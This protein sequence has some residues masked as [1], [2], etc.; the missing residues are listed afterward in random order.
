MPGFCVEEDLA[1]MAN[2]NEV[3]NNIS[4]GEAQLACQGRGDGYHLITENEWLT[5]AENILR[6]KANDINPEVGLQLATST[7]PNST[8]TK[9]T[10]ALSNGS[11]IYNLVGVISQ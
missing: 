9:V 6:V 1:K 3:W 11:L 5:I 10:Y 7:D 2:S 8:S 4:Q